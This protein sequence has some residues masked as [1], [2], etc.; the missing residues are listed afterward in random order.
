M[1]VGERGIQ[2]S[3]WCTCKSETDGF[4]VLRMKTCVGLGLASVCIPQRVICVIYITR[5]DR[6]A[7]TTSQI[8]LVEDPVAFIEAIQTNNTG[9]ILLVVSTFVSPGLAASDVGRLGSRICVGPYLDDRITLFEYQMIHLQMTNLYTMKMLTSLPFA[10]YTGHSGRTR[11]HGQ[12]G[13]DPIVEG[14]PHRLTANKSWSC[15]FEIRCSR[16]S[17]GGP[18]LIAIISSG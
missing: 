7:L 8:A 18:G 2:N 9:N 17:P 1:S 4:S 16:Y 14:V 11:F 6:A 15:S 13:R 3:N 5:L 10:P 12:R